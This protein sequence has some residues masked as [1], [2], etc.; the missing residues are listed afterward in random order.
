MGEKETF[1]CELKCL[2]DA[3]VVKFAGYFTQNAAKY[4]R[5][6]ARVE[7]VLQFRGRVR[8][9]SVYSGRQWILPHT[10]F[11]NDLPSPDQVS[12]VL[13]DTFYIVLD[14]DLTVK[15]T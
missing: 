14:A 5:A 3:Y 9:P 7:E 4:A 8:D 13:K 11:E 12:R 6:C 1:T 2:H 15:I 10:K